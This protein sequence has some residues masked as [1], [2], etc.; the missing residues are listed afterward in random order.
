MHSPNFVE[1]T[2]SELTK[3]SGVCQSYGDFCGFVQ[4]NKEIPIH[5]N[6]K[7]TFVL[8]KT[9]KYNILTQTVEVQC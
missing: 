4:Q 7:R 3:P 9:Q 1:K 8:K 2:Q 6:T 5:R